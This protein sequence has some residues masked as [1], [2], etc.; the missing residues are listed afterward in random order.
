MLNKKKIFIILGVLIL[1]VFVYVIT[2]KVDSY[3][4]WKRAAKAA[5]GFPYQIGLTN[6][7]ITPCVPSQPFNTNCVGEPA[8]LDAA[9]ATELC[10]FK[11]VV[12]TVNFLDICANN[13]YVTGTMAGG[14]GS[15]AL[16]TNAAIS[17]VGL[18]LGGQL[19]AGGNSPVL[20]DSGVLAS[21][22]GCSGCVAQTGL[23][24]KIKNWFDF[25]I[26]GKRDN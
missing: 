6:V 15:E 4:M 8:S 7:R 10:T 11:P 3:F 22:G 20:M 14:M 25:I 19:I 5:G 9:S 13:S 21:G 1:S 16:F 23:T 17:Q 24:E 2:P 12:N 18:T 26:A